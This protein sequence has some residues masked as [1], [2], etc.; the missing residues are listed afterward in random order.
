[1][2]VEDFAVLSDLL[3]GHPEAS[4]KI[5]TGI[6]SFSVR[7][8]DFGTQCFWVN[9]NDGTTEKFSFQACY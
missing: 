1:V 4:D 3:L 7:S 6:E 8:G 5:G 9:R 2:S